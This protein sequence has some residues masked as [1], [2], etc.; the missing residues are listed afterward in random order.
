MNTAYP[1]IP[2]T[3]ITLLAFITTRIFARWSIFPLRWHRRL[4]NHLLLIAF[5]VS[6]LLGLLSVIKVNY[7]LEIPGYDTYL[8][9]HVSFGIALVIIAGLHISWNIRFFLPR[10]FR[11]KSTRVKEDEG[12]S[13]PA[14]SRFAGGDTDG[15]SG[16]DKEAKRHSR[17]LLFLLGMAAIIGQVV[18]IREFITVLSG[19]EL[20]V[21][22]IMAVWMLLTGWGALHARKKDFSDFTL[23]RGVGMLATMT[24]Y[25]V[26]MIA[27]LYML[28]HL[29]FPPGTMVN[30]VH[31]LLA[32]IIVLFPVCFVSG[33][34]FTAYASC[35]SVSSGANRTGRSYAIESLGSLAG[36]FLFSILLGKLF[37]P[38]QLFGVVAGI[39]LLAGAWMTRKHDHPARWQ[40]AAAGILV[41]ALIFAF[42]PDNYVKKIAFPNQELVANLTTRYGNLVVTRQADQVN[43]YE[44]NNLQFYTQHVMVNE[45]AVHFAMVQHREPAQ[46]LL[47][48]GGMAGMTGEILKYDVER[49][50]YLE[51]NPGIF[52]LPEAFA[53]RRDTTGKVEVVK[54]DIR[55]FMGRTGRVFDVVLMNLPPPSSLG[56]NRFYTEEFF[57]LLRERCDSGSVVCTSLPSTANYAE[58]S[59]LEANASLW[60][61]LGEVFG[62]R[63]LLTGE[64]NYFLASDRP[65]TA[66]VIGRITEMG[67]GTEY[68]NRFFL[69]DQLLKMRS[70]E[71]TS[72]F[73]DAVPVNRDFYPFVYV[74]QISYWL[75][76]FGTRYQLLVI[77]PVLLFLALFVRTD[78]IT[79]GLY[80]GGFTAASLE[81]V[82]LLAY[83]VY[84]GSIYLATAMFFAVF[85]G[86][87]AFGSSLG[88]RGLADR[89]L[90]L[91][92]YYLLQFA[93]AGF[94][95]LLPVLVGL[96]GEATTG[97]SPARFL[98]F[99]L[100][101]ILSAAVGY[102]F[103]LASMLRQ[104][105]Y[106]ETS[107]VNYSTDLAGSAF[108]A[109]LTAIVLLPLIG[110]FYT[111]LVVAVLNVVSGSLA[112]SVRGRIG[113]AVF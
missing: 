36:G 109:F 102:E 41:P 28:K 97:F 61:T 76:H 100:I 73:S 7:K 80:T 19:N 12:T 29:L 18:F 23:K 92:R 63:L 74:K 82:L 3:L 110:L 47:I 10:S 105:T 1:L 86:G 42:N 88:W 66:E 40:W 83:Q 59:A 68:V 30:M 17:I 101:F 56:T 26:V 75:S 8:Q 78:R 2:V 81:V 34:L 48:S 113:R 31:S 98:F 9:W 54:K 93:L 95:V 77:I 5:L 58:E 96:T 24:L 46:V 16:A 84:F 57:N 25:P 94:A 89:M 55:T 11:R 6:G 35:L 33:Y 37:H 62:Y 91:R 38:F 107:G 103:L 71:L 53:G 21:G 20:V 85:M 79:A 106:S 44:N 49:I 90:L 67:I 99:V 50:T 69:D 72:Q 22:I 32:A 65:L 27:L 51:S 60:K 70:D 15:L 39:V 13:R 108:G 52:R 64:K 111:C 104:R 45:E 43:V 112:F 14:G 87:L 4:W